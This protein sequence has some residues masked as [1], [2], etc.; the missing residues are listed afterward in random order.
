[1]RLRCD[2]SEEA[3]AQIHRRLLPVQQ[4]QLALVVVAIVVVVVVIVA[5]ATTTTATTT[6][7]NSAAVRIQITNGV[8]PTWVPEILTCRKKYLIVGKFSSK[9]IKKISHF[10]RN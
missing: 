4:L 10:G 5:S 7:A 8:V 6:T 9:N 1:M 3:G 2:Q